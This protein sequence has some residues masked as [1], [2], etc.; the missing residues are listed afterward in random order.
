MTP[1]NPI[2]C[3]Q[4][5]LAK[6]H[7]MALLVSASSPVWGRHFEHALEALLRSLSHAEESLRCVKN[8]AI[9]RERERER[10][11]GREGAGGG[12]GGEE[13]RFRPQPPA[14]PPPHPPTNR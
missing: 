7:R 5:S 10:E 3:F 8:V 14:P 2:D 12:G 13:R 9:A 4:E 6:M 1:F 11:G